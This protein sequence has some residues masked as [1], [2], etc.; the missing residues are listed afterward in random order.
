MLL[1]L[2]PQVQRPPHKDL[3]VSIQLPPLLLHCDLGL[4]FVVGPLFALFGFLAVLRRLFDPALPVAILGHA[5][6]L[7]VVLLYSS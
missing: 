5:C 6:Y 7:L 3:A 1:M 2:G 4:T